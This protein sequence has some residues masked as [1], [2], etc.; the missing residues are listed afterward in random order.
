[1][2]ATIINIGDELLIGQVTNTNASWMAA[3]LEGINIHI[4]EINT[5]A[6]SANA[7]KESVIKA[8]DRSDIILITGGLG[9]TKD[10]ITKNTLCELFQSTLIID[11]GTLQQVSNYFRSRN[12]PLTDINRAQ[13]LVPECCTVIP[14]R[15]GT[16]PC[17]WFEIEGKI[18]ISMPG[19]PFE[20]KWLMSHSLL[21][22]LQA[23]HGT[24]QILHTT[25]CTCGIGESFLA[26]K[27]ESWESSLPSNYRLAY[28]PEAGQVRLRLSC[29]GE[30]LPEL[31][32]ESEQLIAALQQIIP[33]YIYGYGEETLPEVI[34]KLLRAEGKSL[35]TAESCTG[36]TIAHRITEIPGASDYYM[37]GVVSY[38]NA[39]KQLL[40]GVQETT[41][42]QHGAVSKQTA[43]E[44]AQ[45]C[46]E[47]LH[48]DYAI[49]TTGIAGP[50]GGSEEKPVGTVWIAIACEQ[51][52]FF[53]CYHF[54][55][56]RA[57]HQ[58]R[59]TTQALYNLWKII[60]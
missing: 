10:D 24:E 52:T 3:Q 36:G 43:I 18:I 41:I 59:T 56:L 30:S 31:Q 8:M 37:G 32:A 4:R 49:A 39:L 35:A 45:G 33:E 28:L 27:I 60:K 9:P 14:N 53:E 22:R 29:H 11:P 6:D 40:L 25:I 26:E 19:V 5:I 15:V 54:P 55:T 48:T 16:A 47:R 38:S 58:E 34:G 51:G 20:M 57:Q 23:L 12:I 2:E 13:A 7:I 21:P 42:E 50:G 46:R 17:M 1:M 44:M